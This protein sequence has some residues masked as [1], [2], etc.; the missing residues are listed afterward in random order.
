MLH[1]D[2]KNL[3]MGELLM[4]SEIKDLLEADCDL[5]YLPFFGHRKNGRS[6]LIGQEC[7]SQWY[8]DSPFTFQGDTYS[9]AEHWMMSRKALLFCDND[10]HN[11]ILR[12][13][14]P[15]EAKK[16]GRG[17]EGFR[18]DV[19]DKHA[20]AIVI[21]GNMLK[22]TQNGGIRRFLLGTGNKVLTE[23]APYDKV[24]GVGLDKDHKDVCHPEKWRGDNK[25]GFA[26][27]KVRDSLRNLY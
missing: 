23:A 15:G 10:S 21:Y 9:T 22:F 1:K 3:S 19:W 27:M 2:N 14:H 24:W 17:V 4:Y 18:Q 25:L 26:L 11:A 16:I 6:A 20:R 7:L 13:S 5:D 12:S 8:Q